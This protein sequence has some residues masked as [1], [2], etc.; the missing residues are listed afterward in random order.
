MVLTRKETVELT[1]IENK[2]GPRRRYKPCA[3]CGGDTIRIDKWDAYACRRCNIW[4]EKGCTDPRC[5]FCAK[6]P[7]SPRNVN[8]DDPYNT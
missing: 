1:T 5:E 2:K 8:W 3:R 4:C 7:E 6:R